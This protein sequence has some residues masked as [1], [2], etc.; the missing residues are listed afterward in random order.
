MPSP[1]RRSK[2]A[3]LPSL[4]SSISSFLA[5]TALAASPSAAFDFKKAPAANLDFSRL[6]KV[7]IAGDFAGISLY[8]Y[9]GQNEATSSTNGSESLLAQLPNGAFA[10]FA[11]SDASIQSLCTYTRKN[12][13]VAGLILG[14]NFTSLDR[15]EAPS[16]AL[17]DPDTREIKAI[18][19]LEGQV[20]ALYCDQETDMVYLG[21][22]FK[23]KGSTNAVAWHVDDG[24]VE[25]PFAGFN[26][27]VATI[28]RASNG[29]IIFGGAFTS[30]GN[31]ST[32]ASA[33]D[34]QIINLF[35]ADI[36][37]GSS[38][39]SRDFTD[40]TNI[41]CPGDGADG[42]GNTWLLDDDTPGFWEA[43]FGFEFHPSKVR[44]RNT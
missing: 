2:A 40:P 5:A 25:L 1:R 3:R 31:T 44:L 41:V 11:S 27:P 38:A 6:G 12:G 29:H 14:G 9:E 34:E 32:N 19:G 43:S 33:P 16:I 42:P 23:V 13:D 26:G 20:S 39:S 7:G 22:G 37:S 30:L 18:D 8:E 28:T 10:S 17:F 15:E 36:T 4:S 24:W 21:G 35:D